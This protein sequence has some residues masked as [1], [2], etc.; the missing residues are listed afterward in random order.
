[1]SLIVARRFNDSITIV[2]DT[3][4]T[5]SSHKKVDHIRG[6]VV[7]TVMLIPTFSLSFAGD[8]NFAGETIKAAFRWLRFNQDEIVDR[9]LAKHLESNGSTD[10]IAAL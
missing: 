7:K 2:S 10:F 8:E 5:H 6:A 3:R 4:I 1:M 9:L